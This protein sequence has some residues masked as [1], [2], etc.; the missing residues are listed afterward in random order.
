VLR[1]LLLFDGQAEFVA[2]PEFLGQAGADQFLRMA[3]ASFSDKRSKLL[4]LQRELRGLRQRVQAVIPDTET[5]ALLA[6]TQRHRLQ[7]EGLSRVADETAAVVA[8]L[9][10]ARRTSATTVASARGKPAGVAKEMV[11]TVT[12]PVESAAECEGGK[13]A[14]GDGVPVCDEPCT[15]PPL[16]DS[17][18]AVGTP[19]GQ[20]TAAEWGRVIAAAREDVLSAVA[21]KRLRDQQMLGLWDEWQHAKAARARAIADMLLLRRTSILGIPLP[22]DGAFEAGQL[23]P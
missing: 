17:S 13:P 20:L 4:W 2:S 5:Q 15:T 23:P 3:C 19:E 6:A 18:I 22:E 14:T 16:G 7:V 9:V 10:A 11:M 12:E 8:D 21:A 1:R